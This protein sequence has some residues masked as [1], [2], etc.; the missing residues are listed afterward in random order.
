MRAIVLRWGALTTLGG[1]SHESH[2]RPAVR[3]RRRDP[4]GE[5]TGRVACG[6]RCSI[7]PFCVGS[8]YIDEPFAMS[9]DLA[10]PSW[11]ARGRLYGRGLR[12]VA[13]HPRRD[14][15][16]RVVA[17]RER[18]A[19]ASGDAAASSTGG[20]AAN[21]AT[22]AP[23]TPLPTISSAR[24]TTPHAPARRGD[25]AAGTPVRRPDH[26]RPAA[27]APVGRGFLTRT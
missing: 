27:R 15:G 24:S 2:A 13:V 23:R 18:A 12:I 8:L 7:M 5:P 3:L 20:S 17:V 1:P 22:S 19:A 9:G 26:R 21:A 11:H 6:T 16:A 14:R 10:K 25:D 4:P